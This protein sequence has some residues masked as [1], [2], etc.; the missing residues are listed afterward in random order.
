MK[1]DTLHE[2][3]YTFSIISCSILLR[4][5][6]NSDKGCRETQKTHLM[7]NNLFPENRAVYEITR[8]NILERGRP[9]MTIRRMR[10]ACWISKATNAHS[11]YVILVAFSL[12]QRLHERL[13]LLRHT[14]IGCIVIIEGQSLL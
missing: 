8:K 5:E 12:Q 1:T 10:N 6:K 7:F 2:D 14:Y 9:Q 3:R 4:T 13:S 11:E